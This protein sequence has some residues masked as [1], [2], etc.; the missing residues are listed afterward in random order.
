AAVGAVVGAAAAVVGAAA[1]AVVGAV[2]GLAAA[3][4]GAAGGAVGAAAGAAAEVGAAPVLGTGGEQAS[5]SA[6][7]TGTPP[8]RAA[9]V[10]NRRLV[11]LACNNSSDCIKSPLAGS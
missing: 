2:A 9:E 5:N 6:P 1:A 10:S 7:M 11:S 4:V 3:A 8:I